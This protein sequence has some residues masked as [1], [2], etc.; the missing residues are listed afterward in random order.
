MAP[1]GEDADL[2]QSMP[3]PEL[4]PADAA[5][6]LA[7]FLRRESA[8]VAARAAG[9][10]V[11]ELGSAGATRLRRRLQASL[12]ELARLLSAHGGEG[13]RLFAEL[14]RRRAGELAAL[15]L[16]ARATLDEFAL[17]FVAI[18]DVWVDTQRAP[19]TR[20]VA[21]LLA[22]VL[23][24]SSAHAAEVWVRRQ[25]QHGA[26]FQEAALLQ[27]VVQSLDEAILVFETD[28]TVSYAT[29]ALERVLGLD[30]RH[31]V[32]VPPEELGG[33][34][35]ALRLRDR[36]GAAVGGDSTPWRLALERHAPVHEEALHVRRPDG[37]EA[38]VEL[39]ASP[40]VDEDGELRGLIVTLRDRTERYRTF[41]A[42]EEAYSELRRMHGRL[43]SRPH[44]ESVGQL[45]KGAAHA[46]NNHLNV[47]MMRV[48]HLS[49][50]DLQGRDLAAIEQASREIATVVAR[51]QEFAVPGE[52]GEARPVELARAVREL[53][54]LTH[55][56]FGPGASARLAIDVP[57]LPP[58]LAEPDL[59]VE[60]LTSLALLA[61]DLTP[62]GETLRIDASDAGAA[63]VVSFRAVGS[64]VSPEE[65]ATLVVGAAGGPGRLAIPTAREAVE[66]WGG[67]LEV[68]DAQREGVVFRLR[69]PYAPAAPARA[70]APSAV[71][72]AGRVRRV[73][74][75]D[76]DREN[77]EVLAEVLGEGGA[78]TSTA[79]TG[80]GALEEADRS[81]P[82][83][84]LVDL[85]L[86]DMHGWEVVRE[87]KR[88]HPGIR[89]GVVSGLSAAGDP[90]A[91]KVDAVFRKPV[92]ASVL[93]EFVDR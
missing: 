89:V 75:V 73:L 66:R 38:V 22:A 72:P 48:R 25:R 68:G 40:V 91:G 13:V 49:S 11:P 77:A 59:L 31:V 93:L 19:P 16:P 78:E 55:P 5:R 21:R 6:L 82:D 3:T 33:V 85:L 41:Q 35:E 37:H 57:A 60:I 87:L 52:R 86:P 4:R 51:L 1:A 36:R 17:L 64:D 58:V 70:P 30:P 34:F 18:W 12:E 44:L 69:L 15:G 9:R 54:A 67:R 62:A 8:A 84:A 63:V 46:L 2:A 47:L 74:V 81:A 14:Q 27:T 76:D 79:A 92:D 45:V 61:R 43:L 88:R 65:A 28:E 83:V 29:P 20:E 24:E 26:A 32:D 53:L 42:L 90:E 23:A 10:S 71:R 7:E 80:A 50:P 56:E 39:H